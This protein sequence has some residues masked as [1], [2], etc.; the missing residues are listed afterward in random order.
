[1]YP[2]K[3]IEAKWQQY[4]KENKTFQADDAS[5]APKHYILDM[6][7]YPSGAGLHVGHPEGYTAT[8][9][10]SRYYKMK[11]INVLH[12]M[13]WDAFG[14][15]AENYA[16][17]T[18]V[19]PKQTTEN[20]IENFRKQ[21]QSIGFAY[22]WD[23]EINTSSVE[24]YKWTQWFFLFLYKNNLAY[25]KK[26]PVNWCEDCKTVLANEQV[27]NDN[28]ERC[29]NPVIQKDLEQWFFKITDFIEDTE[30][31][32]RTTSG[33]ING[34]EK[35]D[36]PN[37]TMVGQKNWIGKST[38]CN[39]AW[40]VKNHGLQLKTYTT[41]VDTLYGVTFAV[42]SP[43]H[44]DLKNITSNECANAVEKYIEEAHRKNELER[45]SDT[46]E[47][48]GEFTGAYLIH[49]LTGDE[50]PL[51]VAD[52]VLMTYGTGVVMGVPAHDQ[53][54]QDFAKKYDIPIVQAVKDSKGDTFVYDDVDKYSVDGELIESGEF[55]GMSI[56]EARKNITQTLQKKG[57]GE[58]QVQYKL[59][60]WLVSRQRYWGSPIPIV[61]DPEG[62]PHPVKEEHLPLELPTD[63]DFNPKG[64][65]PLASSQEYAQRAEELYGEGWRFEVDTM[66][67][68]VCS[69]WYFFRFMD[70]KNESVFASAEAMKK[71]GP[72]DTYVGGAE[73]TVLH[74]LYARFF[75]KALHKYGYID[76]DEPFLKLRHQGI[77]LGEDNEKMSKS[78]GNVINPDD[79]IEVNGADTLRL[80]EMFMGDFA[81]SKPWSTNG[82]QGVYRFIQRVW[83][84][85]SEKE[86]IE[87][88][89]SDEMQKVM[90]KSIKKV[91]EDIEAFGFN[92]AISQLM[93]FVNAMYKEETITTEVR[94]TF[95]K[96]LSPFA[97]HIAEEFWERGGHAQSISL[98]AWPE[99]DV[100]LAKDDQI[101]FV[102]QINGKVRDAFT[103]SADISKEDAIEQIKQLSKVQKYLEQSE[104]V[105]EIYVPGK[106]VNLVIRPQN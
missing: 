37:G 23:R 20:C 14:L 74:L 30:H 75:T 46:K 43:E 9:I 55:T 98:E 27:V 59:R 4:W 5:N 8:D 10:V 65:S 42:I 35:I 77:I 97:P 29:K 57:M 31:E 92:T 47:K 60:D 95:L 64:E 53:R 22:D 32:G 38:G 76:F 89:P 105:K 19:H 69:S 81:Q 67:T 50:V 17:K 34:L 84:L 83:R 1:M 51:Y 86:T 62:N 54:D 102:V 68:F 6:F 36:W 48:T 96:L 82:I 88:A 7:P 44:P 71:W 78:R 104:I 15:P 106:L 70:P 45:M 26:A 2:H 94:E 79:V 73:H 99:Y 101:E 100:D 72:V 87:G 103:A 3:E 40:N 49:P 21:I 58:K 80:Y 93:I 24:Y 52:Y 66:D 91:T 63:V 28:C 18:K 39:V 16:I 33:L 25:K 41:T 85:F 56:L 12:P 90:H 61:Y 13:G 11:G